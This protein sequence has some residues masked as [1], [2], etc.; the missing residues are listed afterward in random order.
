MKK[1]SKNSKQQQSNAQLVQSKKL[2]L[3][4]LQKPIG[5]V[6]QIKYHKFQSVKEKG[7]SAGQ[8]KGVMDH[9]YPLNQAIPSNKAK[10]GSKIST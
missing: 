5:D 3:I 2:D 6:R 10:Q 8:A 9:H 4:K 1:T 7:D